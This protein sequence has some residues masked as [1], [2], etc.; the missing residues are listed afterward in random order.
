MTA[1]SSSGANL[2]S[3]RP[4]DDRQHHES[5]ENPGCA[6]W[7]EGL[8]A[9]LKAAHSELPPRNAEES[10]GFPF[11]PGAAIGGGVGPPVLSKGSIVQTSPGAF[12][13]SASAIR[14]CLV[15]LTKLCD[16]V[17]SGQRHARAVMTH[18]ERR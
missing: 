1:I 11:R 3:S 5:S 6:L 9:T 15:W 7:R 17:L 4:G 8:V 14:P 12:A 10:L 16:I 13:R 2:A 18:H